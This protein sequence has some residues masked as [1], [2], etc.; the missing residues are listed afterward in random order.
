VTHARTVRSLAIAQAAVPLLDPHV[1]TDDRSALNLRW[2]VFDPLMHAAPGGA[3]EPALAASWSTPDGR[4]WRFRLRAG[5]RWS[6]GDRVTASDVVAALERARDPSMS[7]TLGTTGLYASYLGGATLE[8]S[9]DDEVTITT[10]EPFADLLDLLS[11]IPIV[12]DDGGNGGDRFAGT[13]VFQIT[14]ADAARVDMAAAREPWRGMPVCHRLTWTAEP[15]ATQR[16]SAVM[17]REA[18][19][20]MDLPAGAQDADGSSQRLRLVSVP[21]SECVVLFCNVRSG[22][23]AD[24]RVRQAL[25]HAIDVDGLMADVAPDARALNGP[26]TPLHLGYA[27][28]LPRYTY[29]PAKAQALL[30]SSRCARVDHLTLD[31][32]T[33]VPDAAPAIA[34]FLVSQLAQ[35]GIELTVRRFD[36]RDRYAA[37]LKSKQ[38]DDLACFDSTPASSYRTLREKLHG[39][40]RGPWWQGYTNRQVDRAIDDATRTPDVD[41][42]RAL[43]Q[44]AARL[45]HDDAPWIFLYSPSVL[46]G[47]RQQCRGVTAQPQG[48]LLFETST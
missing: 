24:R 4:T 31:V 30:R 25:N 37:M 3:H 18:D 40:M 1:W 48:R 17:A 45:I 6:N 32:P 9:G 2:S 11:D 35:I 42:R 43:Y 39:A 12:R 5:V 28:D 21:T 10:P 44:K 33:R 23:C 15:D 26:L 46:V 22:P 14:A 29:D 38:M 13:G 19:V 16:W 8:T 47:F 7:G 27:A 34:R 41:R 36:D 20:A